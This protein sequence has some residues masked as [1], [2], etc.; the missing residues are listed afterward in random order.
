VSSTGATGLSRLKIPIFHLSLS[1]S[2]N[3]TLTQIVKFSL[4]VQYETAKNSFGECAHSKRNKPHQTCSVI[5]GRNLAEAVCKMFLPLCGLVIEC[6]TKTRTNPA[7]VKYVYVVLLCRPVTQAGVLSSLPS[8]C[9]SVQLNSASHAA[10][11]E[12]CYLKTRLTKTVKEIA[13]KI[14]ETEKGDMKVR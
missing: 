13:M 10:I 4:K 5:Y 12:L 11:K 1:C 7:A 6:C 2:S 3:V 14:G 8:L 9:C